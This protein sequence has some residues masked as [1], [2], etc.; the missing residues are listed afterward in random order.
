MKE[1][2][3]EPLEANSKEEVNETKE[4]K[5]VPREEK[6]GSK[7]AM[8]VGNVKTFDCKHCPKT[9]KSGLSLR[10]HERIHTG[11]KPYKCET[12]GTGYAS[13]SAYV[14]HKKTKH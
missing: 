10:Q 3:T 12:C 5:I 7:S 9:L 13:S 1:E 11:E 8:E 14:N 6:S 2:K 4:E